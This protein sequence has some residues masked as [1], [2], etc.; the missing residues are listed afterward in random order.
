ML[1]WPAGRPGNLPGVVNENHNFKI[2]GRYG[3]TLNLVV[4][5]FSYVDINWLK[6]GFYV[7]RDDRTKTH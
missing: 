6:E 3:L 4:I 1:M 7:N 2:S 5:R